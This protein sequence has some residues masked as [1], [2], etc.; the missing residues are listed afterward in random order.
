MAVFQSIYKFFPAFL[1]PADARRFF[2]GGNTDLRHTVKEPRFL[3]LVIHIARTIL[4]EGNWHPFN[5]WVWVRFARWHEQEMRHISSL[6]D[7]DLDILALFDLLGRLRGL[8]VRLLRIHRW[9]LNYAEVF[10][11]LLTRM[12]QRWT[13]LDPERVQTFLVSAENSP[14]MR[15]NRQLRVLAEAAPELRSALMDRF[16]REFGHRSFCL[17]LICPRWAEEREEV[18]AAVEDAPATQSCVSCR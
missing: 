10:S 12:L 11:S 3:N 17:D 4:T 1:L 2:P 18:W 6:L 16:L 13:T 15:S 5:Y 14:T 9:S 8:T 7:D